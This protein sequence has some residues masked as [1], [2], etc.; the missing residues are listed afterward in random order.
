MNE[1]FAWYTKAAEQGWGPAQFNLGICYNRGNG[2]AQDMSKALEWFNK[3]SDWGDVTSQST[4]EK[5]RQA[6]EL[7]LFTT[8]SDLNL[9]W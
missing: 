2:V 7:G 8:Y 5:R 3:S 6:D 1:A 4:H 9:H